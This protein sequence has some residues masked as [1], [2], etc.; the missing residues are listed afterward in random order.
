L[1][2]SIGRYERRKKEKT[3]SLVEA[4]FERQWN[5]GKAAEDEE[6]KLE[7]MESHKR[8]VVKRDFYFDEAMNVAIDYLQ[9][10][11]GG[12][13]AGAPQQAEVTR[14]VTPAPV[15]APTPRFQAPVPVPVPQ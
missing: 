10:L 12:G 9:A 11:A 2:A 7:E 13:V 4:E 3:L 15:P 14:T 6:K 5:E 8:P 1:A